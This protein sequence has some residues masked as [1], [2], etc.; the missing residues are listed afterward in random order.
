MQKKEAIFI[1]KWKDAMK[2][3][4]LLKYADK[5]LSSKKI[6]KYL[7][8][9]VEDYISNP[10]IIVSNNYRNQNVKTDLLSLIDAIE[11]Q[12][13]IIGG[14]GVLYVQHDTEGRENIL[15]DYIVKKQDERSFHK[16]E[17]KKYPDDSNEWVFE[18]I[19]QLAIKII[20]NSLYGVHGYDGFVLYNRFIAESITNEGRQIITTAVT[21]FDN[22]LS[23]GIKYNTEDELFQHIMNIKYEHDTKFNGISMDTSVFDITDLDT[24]VIK[25]LINMCAFDASD[26]FIINIQDMIRNLSDEVKIMIYYKNNLYEFSRLPFIR[27]K[28]KYIMDN[29]DDLKAPET[30]LIK[31]DVIL[32]LIDDLWEFYETFVFY[33]YPIYDRVRKAMYTDRSSVLYVDTDSN[34]LGLNDWVTFVKEEVCENSFN[35]P[36]SDIE[37]ISVNLL[38]IFLSKVINSGLL[39]LAKHM[40][41]KEEYGKKYNMKNEFYLSRIIFTDAKKRYVSNSILQEGQLLNNGLGKAD[42]KGFD[43]K[44]AGTKQFLKETYTDICLNDILRADHIDVELIYRKVLQLKKDI[45]LSMEAGES[46]FF[47]QANVNIIEHYA[48]PYSTQGVTSVLLWNTLNPTYAME[49]PTDCDIVPIKEL[50]GPKYSNGKE[51]WPN[52]KFVMEFADKF[53][54]AYDKLVKDIY[55]NPNELIRNMGLKSLAKPKNSEIELPEWFNFLL[56]KEKVIQDAIDLILPILKS[57]GLNGLKT[58]AST[59]YVTNII[60]L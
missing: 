26:Q 5:S 22:F 12:Q 14:G 60:D 49:L 38:A 9:L 45:A 54:D 18:D 46:T 56:N 4:I 47:K 24:K 7:D 21:V 57:L 41:V 1:T 19:L 30:Y 59:E 50:T 20:I 48:N 44:K 33:N 36:V 10:Q 58:N 17:R 25:R 55:S 29:L 28:L 34:F 3:Q 43:F 23:G 40:N 6:D 35:K 8:A 37:F 39:T 32:S 27:D 52:K 31:D 13:L 11:E 2:S 42:I 15:Y 16:K 51:I 53:P